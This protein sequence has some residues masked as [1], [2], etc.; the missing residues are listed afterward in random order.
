ML[1]KTTLNL[2]N[3]SLRALTVPLKTPRMC[4]KAL[5]TAKHHS[6]PARLPEPKK[7][8]ECQC[9]RDRKPSWSRSRFVPPRNALSV[10]DAKARS[11]T[12]AVCPKRVVG[13]V[14]KINR[15]RRCGFVAAQ[16]HADAP[17]ILSFDECF[18]VTLDMLSVT[19]PSNRTRRDE[20]CQLRQKKLPPI[21]PG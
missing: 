6:H 9:E 20:L 5:Q 17:G 3:G 12:L 2:V 7:A 4:G 15:T 19:L 14:G 1:G 21:L 8:A 16:R 13:G 10:R 18:S 11:S